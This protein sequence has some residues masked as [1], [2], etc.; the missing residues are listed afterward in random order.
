MGKFDFK[1]K[2]IL[3]LV[4]L[5]I[6]SQ[7]SIAQ[8]TETADLYELSLEDLMQIEVTTASKKAEK[9]SDAPS[10]IR[11]ITQKDILERG[12]ENVAEALADI[13][14]F[15]ATNDHLS[16]N[17]SAR[18]V[19]GGMR[20]WNKI[21]KVM[22]DGQ[23]T[24]FRPSTAN[25]MGDELIPMDAVER[26][27]VVS[28]PG[29]ALYGANAF[30]GV[31]NI[32]TKSGD[33]L[34]GGT[35]G[36]M[37]EHNNFNAGNKLQAAIGDEKDDFSYL[38]SLSSGN[39]DR[40]GL[41]IPETSPDIESYQGLR[42]ANDISKPFSMFGKMKYN[43]DF[44]ELQLSGSY[45][46][47][48]A[49]GEFQDWGI[50]TGS[51]RV[52]IENWYTRA[53]YFNSFLDDK[54]S[55]N[56][57][58]TYAEGNPTENEQLDVNST[59]YY[60]KR[61]V[62]YKSIDLGADVNF[63][64]ND[65]LNI[66]GGI[67]FTNDNE[68]LLT[69]Y[70]VD[71]LTG[72]ESLYDAELGDTAFVNT[73]IYAKADYDVLDNLILF[74]GLRFDAHSIYDDA[75]NYRGGL[76]Y[77]L[78]QNRYVK[79]FYGTSFKAPAPMQLFTTPMISGGVV[80][81]PN[82]KPEKAKT[83]ELMVSALNTEN[84][85]VLVNGFYSIIDDKVEFIREGNFIEA[86][87]ADQITSYGIEAEVQ[88]Q[89]NAFDYYGNFSW[90]KSK[91]EDVDELSYYNYESVDDEKRLSIAPE[92]KTVHYIGYKNKEHHTRVKFGITWVGNRKASL[93]N[94]QSNVIYGQPTNYYLS[95][96]VTLDLI[97]GSYQLQLF[98]DKTTNLALEIHNLL[99]E[100]F[101][102]PGYAGIDLPALGR[103]V[104]FKLSQSF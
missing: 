91:G 49:F 61:D 39:Y 34:A 26:I 13:P 25:F 57:W 31:V 37:V 1:S 82:L 3:L 104:Q 63:A 98:G 75:F 62:G 36:I 7:L 30:L 24:S 92:Y 72:V 95:D 71:K 8:N 16:Y 9:L 70:N 88:A 69:I 86:V 47:I 100:R 103:V 5:V 67:D 83:V 35:A 21:M 46:L 48:D 22:I 96:Y 93:A 80:G 102:E 27:E 101:A 15:H 10:I 12:Y 55:V 20:A 87:N 38:F 14:G 84:I 77:K 18:G 78:P 97:I 11:V 76:I 94:I 52:S 2:A 54:L 81:N 40:S 85:V 17:Y 33:K 66:G 89:Y 50:M 53:D 73:G 42:T 44:G 45:Q 58:I 74:G 79:L 64:L 60:R 41:S 4:T 43:T 6:L 51:N 32:I 29:S 68:N 65:K 28:G 56:A 59:Q 19:N 99:D 90:Q 23:P